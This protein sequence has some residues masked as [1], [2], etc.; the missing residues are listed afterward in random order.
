MIANA[1]SLRTSPRQHHRRV[2]A[3]AGRLWVSTAVLGAIA[4]LSA[5]ATEPQDA[6]T[7]ATIVSANTATP[8]AA[9][10]K[11]PVAGSISVTDLKR[12]APDLVSPAF[13]PDGSMILG[14]G[15]D[16]LEVGSADGSGL[17]Y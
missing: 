1:Q 7:T 11:T 12:L 4:L 6:T 3:A 9:T 8:A 5:C 2:L 17:R 14:G 10:A 13:S 16:G 15:K